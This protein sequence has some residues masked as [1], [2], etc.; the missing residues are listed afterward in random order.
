MYAYCHVDINIYGLCTLICV[1]HE[2][3]SQKNI[4]TKNATTVSLFSHTIF[5][6][7]KLRLFAVY[8]DYWM[9]FVK[10]N[11]SRAIGSHVENL[12]F[13]QWYHS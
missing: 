10:A 9:K 3:I 5:S 2:P 8:C 13:Y 12:D 11:H 4:H 7:H 6:A 1:L